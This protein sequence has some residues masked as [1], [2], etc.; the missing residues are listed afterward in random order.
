MT[1]NRIAYNN[2]VRKK[3]AG[4]D[5]VDGAGSFTR[6]HGE[7]G[8]VL[9]GA[10]TEGT[11][12]TE[13][14]SVTPSSSVAARRI[15]SSVPSVPPCEMSLAGAVLLVLML[16]SLSPAVSAQADTRMLV[17]G[18]RHA[19]ALKNNGDVFTWGENVGCQLGRA[20]G[21]RAATPG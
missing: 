1:I 3:I 12:G 5:G 16:P 6:R 4:G 19:V 18:T 9:L 14:F 15:C 10:A 7:H 11:E 8:G 13:K 21:N 2:A 20:G 17:F